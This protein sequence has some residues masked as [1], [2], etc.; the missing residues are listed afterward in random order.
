MNEEL[1]LKNCRII[2]K[3]ARENVTI[4]DTL[5]TSYDWN[6]NAVRV[7][8]A[9]VDRRGCKQVNVLI[10]GREHLYEYSGRFRTANIG[11]EIEI[12]LYQGQERKGRSTRRYEFHAKGSVERIKIQE[13]F[14]ELN[15]PIEVT[16]VNISS[17]GI[18]VRTWC[19]SFERHQQIQ[20]KLNMEGKDLK[21]E[22][23]VLRIQNSTLWTEEYGCK[24]L[25]VHTTEREE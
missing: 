24:I 4:G 15:K 21:L 11:N 17:N 9:S 12:E 5:I 8:M 20:I 18:L 10:I 7:S 22:C 14:I 6:N 1:K 19:D 25:A 2:I 23:E 3:D 16:A 13:Q